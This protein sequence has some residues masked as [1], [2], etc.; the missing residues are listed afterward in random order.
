MVSPLKVGIA[1]RRRKGGNKGQ[2]ERGTGRVR[3]LSARSGPRSLVAVPSR[4]KV[5]KRSLDLRGIERGK[6]GERGEREKEKIRWSRR[7]MGTAGG[8]RFGRRSSLH[9]NPGKSV[10]YRQK[11]RGER[12]KK[13][14]PSTGEGDE[15]HGL[16]LISK[17][18][19]LL[20]YPLHHDAARRAWRAPRQAEDKGKGKGH[21][22]KESYPYGSDGFSF[23]DA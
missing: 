23:S 15:M 14:G 12:E 3:T 16:P 1:G 11:E 20:F 17:F 19:F 2:Y 8:S 5:K 4:S 21:L 18:F 13:R 10:V 22:T 9:L 6:K 7:L